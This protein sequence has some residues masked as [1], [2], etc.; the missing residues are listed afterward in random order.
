MEAHELIREYY[1]FFNERRLTAASALFAA[2]AVLELAPFAHAATGREAYEQFAETWLSAFPDAIFTIARVEQ[3]NETMCEVDVIASGTHLGLLN[4]GGF[5]Q[6]PT[7]G[8]RISVRLRELLEIQQGAIHYAS[9][10]CDIHQL[11]RELTRINYPTLM[12]RLTTV[13]VLREELAKAEG[14]PGRQRDVNDRL[15]TALDAARRAAR[16][17][18]DR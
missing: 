5:G 16:P 4:L 7:S 11:V 6:V 17:Q 10:E 13:C 15:G 8:R 18:F 14:D 2:D 9:V 12:A 3:R 1:R